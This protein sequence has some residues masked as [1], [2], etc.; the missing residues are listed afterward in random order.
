MSLFLSAMERALI[1][2]AR[3]SEPYCSFYWEL[4]N[5]AQR[6]ASS[7]GLSDSE[8]TC[9]WWHFASEYLTD[10]AI[11]CALKPNETLQVWLRDTVLSVARRPLADWIGPEFRNHSLEMPQGHLET[12]HLTWSLAIA[13]DLAGDVFSEAERA[14]LVDVLENKGMMLCRNWIDGNRYL[15]NWR[16]ILLAGY[17]VAAAVLDKEEAMA[18]AAADF[19]RCV[20]LFQPD[21]SYGESLQYG[22]YAMTGLVYTR[23]ALV[24]RRPDWASDL[25]MEPYVFKP[26]WDAASL[27]YRKPL[28]G[29]G[30]YPIPR[31]ANFGD[32]ASLYGASADNLL[33]LAVRAKESHPAMAG[34]ARWLFD[35]LYLPAF[36]RLPQDRCSF[37]FVNGYRFLTLL[38]LPQAVEA[39]TPEVAGV[40]SLETFSCGHVLARH[41]LGGRTVLAARTGGEPLHALA[42]LHGDLNSFIL[43]HNEERMLADGGHACYRNLIHAIETSTAS[44]N[45][46]T[47]TVESEDGSGAQANQAV[48]HRMQQGTTGHRRLHADGSSGDPVDRGGR[49]LLTERSGAITAIVSEASPLYGKPIEAFTR[50]WLLCDEHVLF[51][52]DFIQASQPIKT[53][54]HWLL[55]N[56]D[57][58]LDLKLVRP[59]RL[60]A[61]RGNAGMKLFHLG[62]GNLSGPLYGYIHDAYHPLPSQ[63]SEGK[64]GSGMVVRWDDREAAMA[65]VTTHAICLDTPGL[66]AGWHL[67][68]EDGFAAVIESPDHERHWKLKVDEET[69][70]VSVLE[71]HAGRTTQVSAGQEHWKLSAFER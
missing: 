17:A 47:F 1:N 38:L 8:A 67:K 70:T 52:V 2:Q 34:L 60:V 18:F 4:L 69:Q 68:T 32:S 39:L 19:R 64:P 66:I 5:R 56:R 13:L 30:P 43:V 65:S 14:E 10:G 41:R 61:R 40:T 6:R 51:V 71:S 44:H 53:S 9:E 26:R 21:G 58:N 3:T 49:L 33:H 46:C 54:W 48:P 35:T 22:N 7:P 27:F 12:A 37:G 23:E 62:K 63:P 15:N 16:C 57:D 25:P 11:A 42:H 28:S 20:D 36:A 24:R 31:S 55:N 59:D 50:V 29:W 45:T